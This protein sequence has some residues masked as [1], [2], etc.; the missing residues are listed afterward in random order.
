MLQC[1]RGDKKV[2]C[3]SS[4]LNSERAGLERSSLTSCQKA[5]SCTSSSM[6]TR[7]SRTRNVQQ[8]QQARQ[9]H[10]LTRNIRPVD[11]WLLNCAQ[12]RVSAKRPILLPGARLMRSTGT[13][14]ISNNLLLMLPIM[15][16]YRYSQAEKQSDRTCS[17]SREMVAPAASDYPGLSRAPGQ[18]QSPVQQLSILQAS[19]IFL[20]LISITS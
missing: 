15:P 11:H 20:V 17:F 1:R 18:Q 19:T 14:D 13:L 16:L 5:P 6:E 12:G 10:P 2:E 3:T 9:Q 8:R 7:S 4:A